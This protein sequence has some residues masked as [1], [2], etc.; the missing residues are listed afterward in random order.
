M[1]NG[2]IP[3]TWKSKYFGAIHF[4]IIEVTRTSVPW[5]L[6]PPLWNNGCYFLATEWYFD[7]Q[8]MFLSLTSLNIFLL[9]KPTGKMFLLI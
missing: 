6:A 7:I 1:S 5:T 8:P 3:F 9:P 4:T 2:D